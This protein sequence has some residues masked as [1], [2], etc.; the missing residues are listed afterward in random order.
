[1]A[2]V[3][4][5]KVVKDGEEFDSYAYG[6][7]LPLKRGETGFFEQAFTSVE[8]AKTNLRNLLLTAKGERVMQPNFGSGLHSVLFEQIDDARFEDLLKK[9]ILDSVSFW[10]PYIDI[11]D[12]EVEITNEL[13]DNNQANLNLT[14]TVGSEIDLQE[15]TFTVQG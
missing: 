14:F 11:K 3:L 12:I 9:T 7:T 10:L 4:G 2:Y 1:M 13:R 15:L 6:I 8:Q 5:R